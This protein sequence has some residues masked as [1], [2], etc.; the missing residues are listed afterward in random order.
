MTIK[1][2]TT[3]KGAGRPSFIDAFLA[4]KEKCEHLENYAMFR[5]SKTQVAHFFGTSQDTILRLVKAYTKEKYGQEMTYEAFMKMKFE[6]KGSK[7]LNFMIQKSFEGRS[8]RLMI[9]TA[10]NIFGFGKKFAPV[11]EEKPEEKSKIVYI[12][13]AGTNNID[14]VNA[15]MKK[16]QDGLQDAINRQMKE[17]EDND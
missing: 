13:I 8:D 10:E 16:Q 3:K 9:Y 1:K 6:E 11:E 5:A 17:E 15:I 4:D 12:P 14:E 7:F 2:T